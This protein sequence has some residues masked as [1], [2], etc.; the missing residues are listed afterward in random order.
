MEDD[1]VASHQSCS[2]C[3]ITCSKNLSRTSTIWRLFYICPRWHY[4]VSS[5]PRINDTS[6]FKDFLK[7]STTSWEIGPV[8]V[9]VSHGQCFLSLLRADRV[10][11]LEA[12]VKLVYFPRYSPDLNQIKELFAE[13]RTFI[14]RH[15]QS[16]KENLGIN[17]VHV[18]AVGEMM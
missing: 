16:Y 18:C 1:P 9:C 7:A 14:R 6:V 8:K 17:T 10:D 2:S 12:S 5:V 15:W 3:A 11:V 4:S 13:L